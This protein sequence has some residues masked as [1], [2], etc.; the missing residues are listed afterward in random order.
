[1]KYGSNESRIVGSPIEVFDHG[2]LNNLRDTVPYC[3]K[4]SEERTKSFIIL[5]LN[6]FEVPRLRRF[7]REG[8]KVRDKPGD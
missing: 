5:S 7:I 8:L 3:L 6:G 2:R 1:L 4:S